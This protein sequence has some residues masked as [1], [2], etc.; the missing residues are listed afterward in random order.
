MPKRSNDL[1]FWCSKNEKSVVLDTR[2]AL[3]MTKYHT[4]KRLSKLKTTQDQFTSP[5]T[6]ST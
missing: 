3:H 4:T 5:M 6:A 1:I 2:I